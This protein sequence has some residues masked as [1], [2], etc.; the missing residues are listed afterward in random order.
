MLGYGVRMSYSQRGED[1]I[2]QAKL[3]TRKG[4]YVDVGSYH[5]T[6][7]SNTYALYK[8]GWMGLVID[9]NIHL[10]PLYTVFRPRDIFIPKGIAEIAA[11]R[12]YYMFSD[13]A[14]NTF[15]DVSVEEY[16]KRKKVTYIG[17]R[18]AQLVPLQNILR[19]QHIQKIDFLNIDVEGLDLEVLRSHDWSIKPT[20]IAI[21]D[22]LYNPATP[23]TSNIFS[24]LSDKGYTL[25]GMAGETLIFQTHV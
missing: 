17:K 11:H 14:Y 4:I 5:P 18:Q 8:R 2:V 12:T 9:P 16:K 13:G 19:V 6:L 23:L 24:F 15:D 20:V 7:Y 3:R 1:V 21:E 10:K 22:R 25:I